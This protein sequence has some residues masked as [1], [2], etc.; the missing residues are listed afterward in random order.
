M[1][2]S[3]VYYASPAELEASEEY[4]PSL[5]PKP[6]QLQQIQQ[7]PSPQGSTSSTTTSEA[8]PPSWRTSIEPDPLPPHSNPQTLTQSQSEAF[9]G[10]QPI[11]AVHVGKDEVRSSATGLAEFRIHRETGRMPSVFSTK[12]VVTVTKIES[13]ITVGTIRFHTITSNRIDLTINGRE[14]SIA[15]SGIV[16]NRWSFLSTTTPNESV[17]YCWKKDRSTRGAM[18]EDS[19]RSGNV[20]ARM[21]GDL[22]S[23]EKPRLSAESYDEIVV[24]AIAMAEAARRQ[25]RKSDIV[26]IASAIGDFT[27]SHGGADGAGG[28]GGGGGA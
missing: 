12:P 17:R 3:P 26:D 24:S 9:V 28:D 4:R 11:S 10:S 15:H 5:P 7:P 2:D 27:S 1:Q 22:L 16:H 25:K 6:Q 18:L 13:A 14:T 19:K 21:K 23:F 8:D 20:L